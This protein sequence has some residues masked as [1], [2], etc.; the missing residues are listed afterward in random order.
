M[1]LSLLPHVDWKKI[2]DHNI[3]P[4]WHIEVNLYFTSSLFFQP[5]MPSPKVIP[6][7]KD[8][9][10]FRF[11]MNLEIMISTENQQTLTI[12]LVGSVNCLQKYLYCSRHN[13]DLSKFL[14]PWISIVDATIVVVSTVTETDC[15]WYWKL[16]MYIFFLGVFRLFFHTFI[17]YGN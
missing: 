12:W 1:L 9:D 13:Y 15:I 11:V 6:A 5:Q 17:F 7:L 3:L 4:H 16:Y 2:K 8:P 10:I 14:L